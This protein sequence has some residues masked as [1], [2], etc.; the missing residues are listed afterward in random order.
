MKPPRNILYLLIAVAALVG[1]SAIVYLSNQGPREAYY[2]GKPT[3]Y[4]LRE[5]FRAGG[6]QS[7]AMQAFRGMGTNAF[8]FL[9][10]AL[11]AHDSPPSYMRFRRSLTSL[12]I[13]GRLLPMPFDRG[14]LRSAASLVV[15]NMP[16]IAPR[17]F[18]DLLKSTNSEVREAVFSA[19]SNRLGKGD[20]DQAP[21][22]LSILGDSN[23]RVRE[24]AL[25]ALG[26]I[27]P[28]AS[29]AATAISNAS[30]DPNLDVRIAA[31]WAMW[32]VTH[33][34]NV[35]VPVLHAALSQSNTRQRHWAACYLQNIEGKNPELLSV[36]LQSLTNSEVGV[37]MSAYALLQGYGTNAKAAVPALLT[38]LQDRSAPDLR[39]RA[40]TALRAI[41]PETAAQVLQE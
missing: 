20:G 22:F 3:S 18:L 1:V 28:G 7:D 24:K 11:A 25:S 14:I 30:H 29:D 32:Q 17:A 2:Q 33:E 6:N 13:L 36:F 4:W 31:A 35:P 34:T 15:L 26:R 40:K 12:P 10:D 38:A 5:V 16:D 9:L 27:G 19:V 21:V 37:R 23:P 8:P 41:D 39:Q